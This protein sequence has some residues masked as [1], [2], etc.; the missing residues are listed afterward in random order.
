MSP[1]EQA[2]GLDSEEDSSP[3]E[4]DGEKTNP[5]ASRRENELAKWRHESSSERGENAM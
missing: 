4:A 5:R 2:T 3:I 1:T